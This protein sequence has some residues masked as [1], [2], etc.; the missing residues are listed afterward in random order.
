MTD[1]Q[2]DILNTPSATYSHLVVATIWP[3]VTLFL[4]NFPILSHAKQFGLSQYSGY[5]N[6][7]KCG[8]TPKSQ[9]LQ[10]G[11]G[12]YVPYTLS[13]PIFLFFTQ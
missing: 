7:G 8:Q 1:Y 3:V 5:S 2:Q 11:F 10:G 13:H 12:G 4:I 6:S 9:I